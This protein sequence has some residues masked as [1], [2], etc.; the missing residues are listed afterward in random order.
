MPKRIVRKL[1][2]E[3]HL[4]RR[5][6]D[7]EGNIKMKNMIYICRL[8]WTGLQYTYDKTAGFLKI[9]TV[10]FFWPAGLLPDIP[11]QYVMR[12]HVA[13][14]QWN[15]TK[16]AVL[17]LLQ[18]TTLFCLLCFISQVSLRYKRVYEGIS[19]FIVKYWKSLRYLTAFLKRHSKR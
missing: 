15:L 19:Q 13:A 11:E 8:D 6:T 10:F 7:V 3:W 16:C 1:Q 17:G 14:R 4:G 5:R 18:L 12:G 9:N 2:S